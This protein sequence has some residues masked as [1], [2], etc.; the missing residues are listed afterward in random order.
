[1]GAQGSDA[2]VLPQLIPSGGKMMVD[3]DDIGEEFMAHIQESIPQQDASIMLQQLV[4]SNRRKEEYLGKLCNLMTNLST[5]VDH[6]AGS[7][8][9]VEAALNEIRPT[10]A[11]G[12]LGTTGSSGVAAVPRQG[13]R[14]S[15]VTPPGRSS[16]GAASLAPRSA[17]D[18]QRLFEEKRAREESMRQEEERRLFEVNQRRAEEERRKQAMEARLKAEE[19]AR[20][21]QE[22]RRKLEFEEQTNGLLSNIIS[23]DTSAGGLFDIDVPKKKKGGLFDD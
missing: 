5:K 23:D 1:M 16:L 11:S 12:T 19:E 22:R 10:G 2:K 15:W 14:G 7:Q 20:R 8:A 17:E 21:E 18:D 4:E 9:K 6:I 13:S 3:R